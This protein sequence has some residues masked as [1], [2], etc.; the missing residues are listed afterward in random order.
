M[1][2]DAFTSARDVANMIKRRE[3]SSVEA[4]QFYLDR[5]DKYDSEINSYVTVAADHALDSARRCDETMKDRDPDT[6]P[7]F[8]G[9][10]IPIKDLTETAGIRTTHGTKSLA[11][12]IPEV[13][14]ST[15]RRIR[16]AGFVIL[17]KTN[18]PEFGTLPTTESELNGACHNPWDPGRSSGGSS[19]GAAAAIAAGLAPVAHGSDGAG[20]IRI[21]ASCCGVFGIKPSR[22]RISGSPFV[23]EAWAGFST[24]G[25]IA[26]TVADAAA[27]L[28][29]MSGYEPGDPYW[30]PAPERPFVEEV[31]EDPGKLRV[32]LL[33]QT[34]T[35]VPVDP[36][37]VKAAT[38]AAELLTSLGHEI[39]GVDLDWLDPE[40]SSHFIKI[41]QTSTAYYRG[42][43]DVSTMEPVNQ[44]LS[45]AGEATSS[46]AY[47]HAL[48]GLHD[49]AR[50]AV[51]QWENF[52]V[53]LTPTLALPPVPLGWMFE[54]PDPWMQ[55][56][57]AGMFIPFTPMA[58]IT[59]QP[60]VSLPLFWD[61]EGLPI[62]VQLVGAPADEATLIRLSSQIE[63]A[64]P[65]RDKHP[66]GF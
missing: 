63:E 58:N 7:P 26:R 25:P 45:E 43:I 23:G 66:P 62:G 54:D 2:I 18:A 21:P 35:G 65:W 10:P 48:L 42:L 47:I 46:M 27:L 3:V 59:G 39:T 4:T 19:G 22:G 53:M 16:E 51:L 33:T 5:I 50:Q 40:L 20:S 60:A 34:P 28:D 57:R 41:V 38:D 11:D 24:E 31:G 44:A 55:L 30:A 32:G 12:H 49:V 15:V 14:G 61:D 56:V 36:A 6:L 8:H 64:R 13:E 9:V 1:T 37:C 29:V 17:G 52:D